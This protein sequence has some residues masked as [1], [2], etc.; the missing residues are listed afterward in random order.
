MSEQAPS[1][2]P[3]DASLQ[4]SASE[5]A[6]ELFFRAAREV[7][8]VGEA[9]VKAL[10]DMLCEAEQVSATGVMSAL[11]PPQDEQYREEPDAEDQASESASV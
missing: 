3:D 1:P 8:G 7:D 2:I 9:G 4:K 5:R 6:F 10:Q 11:F